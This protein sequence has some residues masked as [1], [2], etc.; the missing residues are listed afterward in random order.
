MKVADRALIDTNV[1]LSATDQGRAEHARAIA[2]LDQWPAAGTVLY[3]SGQILRE[4]LSVSTRPEAQN[5]LGMTQADAVTNARA[6]RGRLRV[7]D[8][9][10]KVL[11]RLLDLLDGDAQCGGKQ[12]HDANLVATALVH[13]IGAVVTLNVEDFIR[14]EEHVSVIDLAQV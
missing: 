13:G 1:L 10:D 5:G 3:A 9:N 2:V 12:V 8:E 7:L 14:F 4:Y 11:D 6:L